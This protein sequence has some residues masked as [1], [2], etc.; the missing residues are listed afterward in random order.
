MKKIVLMV[1]AMMTMTMSFAENDNSNAVKGVE[2]YDMT[3]NI[4]KLAVT[5]GLTFDQME[6]VEDIHHQF[7]QEMMMAAY[8]DDAEREAMVDK[9]V[10]KDVRYMHY[11][12]NDKQYRTY[13][14]LLNTTLRNRGLMK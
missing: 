14:M 5:L 6:A 3:V 8:A 7:S 1:A 4:R 11:V 12:L 13:L 10:K 9:A 2:A